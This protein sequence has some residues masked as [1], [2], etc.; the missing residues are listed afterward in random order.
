M[1]IAKVVM[2][3]LRAVCA[4]IAGASE[5]EYHT[6]RLK[7]RVPIGRIIQNSIGDVNRPTKW[8]DQKIKPWT[9]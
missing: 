1:I 3:V 4:T 2:N 7:S 9:K 6:R 5:W 8:K